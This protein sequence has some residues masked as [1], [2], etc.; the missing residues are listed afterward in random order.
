MLT[1][2][3]VIVAVCILGAVLAAGGAF[4]SRRRTSRRDRV[5]ERPVRRRVVEEP[6]DRVVEERRIV[7]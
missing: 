1:V 6:V 5:V 2:V 3:L 7:D 4:D